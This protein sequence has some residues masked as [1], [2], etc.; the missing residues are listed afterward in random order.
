MLGPFERGIALRYLRSKRRESFI[1]VIALFA[2][3]GIALG[4]ATLIIVMSVMNG[5]RA[6]LIGK[7][8]GVNGHASAYI[9]ANTLDSYEVIARD[10]ERLEEVDTALPMVEGQTLASRG[11]VPPFG[12]IVRGYRPEDL[13]RKGLTLT[14]GSMDDMEPFDVL[15]GVRM[16]EQKGIAL[17]QGY[18]VLNLLA[19]GSASPFGRPQPSQRPVRV[20]G[21]FEVGMSEYDSN[22]IFTTLETAQKLQGMNPQRLTA[23]EILT[24]DAERIDDY[25]PALRREV[26]DTDR[27]TV[28]TWK[29]MNSSLVQALTVERNVMF[30]ILTLIILV[31]AFN[32][33]TGQIMLVKDKG[34]DIAILRTMGAPRASIQRIFLITGASIGII[35]TL[36]GFIAGLLIARNIDSLKNTLESLAGDDVELFP[37]TIYFL[38]NLPSKVDYGEVTLVVAMAISLS[39]LSSLYP[40]W[41]A[42]KVDPV[43][44]LRYE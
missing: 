24:P 18:N 44:A 11:Q 15:V 31:A 21:I 40:A 17:N 26:T 35:G 1:S 36:I 8:L 16:A 33:I 42:S 4:V 12:V 34:R 30:M 32:I 23:I 27:A 29:D 28:R 22:F 9:Y 14:A 7:I 41:R 2:L 10:L 20:V 5:F 38:S 13:Q 6:E 3:I 37:A 39:V 19:K 25:A 43:E